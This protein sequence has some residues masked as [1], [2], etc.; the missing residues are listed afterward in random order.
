MNRALGWAALGMLAAITACLTM[1]GIYFVER[2]FLP[3]VEDWHVTS[4]RAVPGA[5]EV[6]GSFRKLRDC[7]LVQTNVILLR[8]QSPALVLAQIDGEAGYGPGTNVPEGHIQWGPMRL[9]APPHLLRAMDDYDV[10]KV[11]GRHRCHLLWPQET[12][13]GYVPAMAV[14][15]AVRKGVAQ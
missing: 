12:I 6:S 13:Y 4:I 9:P 5:I 7:E 8:G 11:V 15:E 3:V 1:L 2:R 14:L 10:I